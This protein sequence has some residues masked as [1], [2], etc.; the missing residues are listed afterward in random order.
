VESLESSE[1]PT[2]DEPREA[3]TFEPQEEG[4]ASAENL[5][6]AGVA[7]LLL[8]KRQRTNQLDGTTPVESLESSERPTADEPR[9]AETFEP[10]EEGL[11]SAEN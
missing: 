8:D 2:A 1:R 7:L 9:E 10:Q 4:L 5:A 11:A 6:A 3:E